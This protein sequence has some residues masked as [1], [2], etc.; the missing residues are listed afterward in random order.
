MLSELPSGSCASFVAFGCMCFPLNGGFDGRIGKNLRFALFLAGI[1]F[2]LGASLPNGRIASAV[3][4][5]AAL[6]DDGRFSGVVGSSW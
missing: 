4:G 5:C 3:M 6:D 1:P 2:I